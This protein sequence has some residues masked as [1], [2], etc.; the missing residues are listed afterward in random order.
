MFLAPSLS[1]LFFHT[2]RWRA[3]TPTGQIPWGSKGVLD[4]IEEN[5]GSKRP[6]L[7]DRAQ[8]QIGFPQIFSQALSVANTASE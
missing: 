5:Q 1:V 2:F 3:K 7:A 4:L 6:S 8:N